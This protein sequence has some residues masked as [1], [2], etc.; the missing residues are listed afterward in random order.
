MVD[1]QVSHNWSRARMDVLFYR[2]VCYR[3]SMFTCLP[4]LEFISVAGSRLSPTAFPLLLLQCL[5]LLLCC[6]LQHINHLFRG[7]SFETSSG[8]NFP[9]YR[10]GLLFD[11]KHEGRSEKNS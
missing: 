6:F 10:K 3:T 2:E 11:H 4:P 1:M 9:H 5:L 8:F 7:A